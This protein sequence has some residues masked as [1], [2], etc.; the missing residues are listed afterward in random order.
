MNDHIDEKQTIDAR[1]AVKLGP[2]YHAGFGEI[3]E[4]TPD[5]TDSVKLSEQGNNLAVARCAE[6]RTRRGVATARLIVAAPD[7]LVAAEL[8][9][10]NEILRGAL[11]ECAAREQDRARM[12]VE[13]V[14]INR[15]EAKSYRDEI[16]ENCRKIRAAILRAEAN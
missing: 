8:G 12:T 5:T 10:R 15:A 1:P 14:Q 4:G 7:L 6:W 11:S 16:Q 3:R 2:W 9:L 13:A